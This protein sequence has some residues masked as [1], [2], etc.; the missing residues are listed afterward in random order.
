MLK[1]LCL[2]VA[3]VM[4]AFSP[5][6]VA[7]G[8]ERDV[9]ADHFAAGS[10]VRIE[11]PVAGDLL[12]AGGQVDVAAPVRGDAIVAGGNVR[13]GGS[14]DKSVY[15]AGGQLTLAG[16]VANNVRAAGGEVTLV[17]HAEVG[18]N[19][20]LAGGRVEVGG[21]VKG[22]L[23]VAGGEVF[24]N[25]AVGGDVLITGGRVELGP[26]ARIAG[27][28]QYASQNE[29]VID[30]AA[31][32]VGG[33]ERTTW[34][35]SAGIPSDETARRIGRGVGW[36]WTVGL[37]V[38]AAVLVALLPAFTARIAVTARQRTGGSALAGFIALVCIPV[39]ALILMITLIGL[40]LGLVTL[41]AYFALLPVSYV[42][43]AIALGDG[44]L[45]RLKPTA[46]AAIGWRIGA[47]ALA[48]LVLALLARVPYLGGSV[49]LAALLIGLGALMLQLRSSPDVSTAPSKP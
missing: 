34:R 10:S 42:A 6:A 36:I 46:Y 15:A 23:Q 25:G 17:R 49:V 13:L 38:L 16:T 47:A 18:G 45:V 11:Q 5:P 9:G 3:C 29:A 22:Y 40:P 7:R 20:S 32:I 33:V 41:F 14:L 1:V 28:L 24:I 31:Q 2:A 43:A 12:A 27:R 37:I 26:R 21:V 30:P 4:A 39:A 19:A 35:A 8:E 44:A 48:V